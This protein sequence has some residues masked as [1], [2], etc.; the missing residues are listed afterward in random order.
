MDLEQAIKEHDNGTLTTDK[1][2]KIVRENQL[3]GTFW[4]PKGKNQS[5]FGFLH[6]H[7]F[8]AKGRFFQNTLKK[9][10]QREI[11]AVHDSGFSE[12]NLNHLRIAVTTIHFSWRRLYDRDAFVYSDPRLKALD[13]YLKSYISK[14]LVDEMLCNHDF[15]FKIIDIV[16]GLAKE[17]SYYRSR[18]M[19]FADTFRKAYPDKTIS[20]DLSALDKFTRDYI[21]IN[22]TEPRKN[23][24][25]NDIIDILLNLKKNTIITEFV[26]NYRKTFP[27]MLIAPGEIDNVKR[28]H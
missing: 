9:H 21:N 25:M 27:D 15:L 22:F 19:D 18:L 6:H 3:A 11:D 5:R 8:D 10:I 28:W 13:T 17:D 2:T 14:N 24:F 12:S 4:I 7:I 16:L 1:F 26:D 23:K 20:C